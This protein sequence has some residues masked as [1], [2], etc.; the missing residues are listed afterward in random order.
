MK[1]DI[2]EDSVSVTLLSQEY[3][4]AK[5][6]FD[7]RKDMRKTK[8]KTTRCDSNCN[9]NFQLLVLEKSFQLLELRLE[10]VHFH[11]LI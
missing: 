5:A 2:F 7:L 6:V 1:K 4:T 11:I 10:L 8:T 3:L 9:K